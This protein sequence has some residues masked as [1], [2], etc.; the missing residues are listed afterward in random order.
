VIAPPAARTRA[1]SRGAARGTPVANAAD[2]ERNRMENLLSKLLVPFAVLAAAPFA[3]CHAH[4]ADPPH[5]TSPAIDFEIDDRG[6]GGSHSP[7]GPDKVG[8]VAR[9]SVS[10]VDGRAKMQTRDGEARYEL[11]AVTASP[12]NRLMLTLVRDLGNA[13]DLMVE[14]T[15]AGKPGGRLLIAR[16]DRAD[17][18][19]TQVTAQVH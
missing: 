2:L 7:S 12:D 19:T 4:A 10:L 16:I 3:A 6:W 17:G 14:S 8:H 1:R 9:W 11:Q 5:A 15:I 18:H 13:R